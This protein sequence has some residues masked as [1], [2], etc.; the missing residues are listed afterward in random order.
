MQQP[1]LSVQKLGRRVSG[2]WLWRDISF[3]LFEHDCVGLVAP[4]GTGKTLLMR[5]L[6]LLDPI[7]Q[8][9]IIF[10]GRS[11][12]DWTLPTYRTHIMYLPQ[13][14]TAFEG[15]VL[16]NLQQ[17]FKL[18]V[19]QHLDFDRDQIEHWL[20]Q[21]GRDLDYLNLPAS[22]L[23]GGEIQLLALLRS[24]QLNPQILLLDEPTSSL[25]GDTVSRVESLIKTWLR[26][27]ERACLVTSHD[28]Q[29]IHR[30]TNRKLQ[31]E[32]FM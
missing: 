11:L 28:D 1:L 13:R 25:D 14:A 10:Q 21:L 32:A 26:Q 17:V 9:S 5:N 23:S 4:S 16:D 15:S 24:L 31:L 22:Q 7:Q 2:R 18:K 20:Y 8:G 3:D 29:Q 27:P 12:A 6:I 19:Y 30:L